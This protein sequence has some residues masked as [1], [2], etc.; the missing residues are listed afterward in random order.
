MKLVTKSQLSFRYEH[1]YVFRNCK[2]TSPKPDDLTGI[3]SRSI[4]QTFAY[5]VSKNNS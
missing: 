2:R 5:Y 1:V 4:V 3:D